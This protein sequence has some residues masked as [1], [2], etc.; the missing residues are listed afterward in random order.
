[1][2]ALQDLEL[3]IRTADHGS[4][5]AAARSL[6]MTPATASAA[7]KRLEA[8]VGAPLFLRSTRNLRLTQAG[9]RFL[10]QC[11][12]ALLNLRAACA[13]LS[14]A[15][16]EIRETL[17]VSVSSDLGRNL[18]LPWLEEFLLDYPSVRLRIQLSD[19]IADVYRDPVDIAFRY[20]MPPDSQLIALPLELSGRRLLCAAPAYV[21]KHGMPESPAEL[22]TELGRHRSLCFTLDEYV[23]DRWRFTR[24]QQSLSVDT[25]AWRISDDGEAVH[26]WA[27]AG[28]GIACKSRLDIA[29]D[30]AAGRLIELC[31]DWQG[32]AVPLYM[33]CADRRQLSPL[34]TAMRSFIETRCRLLHGAAL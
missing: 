31:P 16:T 10:P 18:I 27:L 2:K 25:D 19:R 29:L 8:E 26:R 7:L 22:S 21:E 17:Q 3:F 34:V 20:G 24:G 11:R 9:E 13:E 12:L 28:L 6:D 1:M 14:A 4:I 32:E 30:L 33:L 15:G 23:H 5:S